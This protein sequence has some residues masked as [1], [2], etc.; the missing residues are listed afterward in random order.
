[1]SNMKAKDVK[2]KIFS[3]FLDLKKI[4]FILDND[5][6]LVEELDFDTFLAVLKFNN[7]QFNAL[8]F[9]RRLVLK[10]CEKYLPAENKGDFKFPNCDK[11]IELKMSFPNKRNKIN[12]RQI[13]LWQDCDYIIGFCDYD[14]HEHKLYYLTHQQMVKE[15]T[16]R[17]TATHGTLKANEN[18]ENI[19]YSI[20]INVDN[21]S[22]EK[23]EAPEEL[24]NFVFS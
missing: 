17:G 24:K 20:T 15:V 13:R 22:W 12:I 21:N 9:E 3:N 10:G 23:Y 7:A 2:K 8:C 1:M 6:R 14:N 18:N 19:E 4:F 11:N 5:E 16:K